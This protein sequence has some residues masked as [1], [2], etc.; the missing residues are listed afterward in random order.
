MISLDTNISSRDC[1]VPLNLVKD[2]DSASCK[3]DII[4]FPTLGGVSQWNAV[5]LFWYLPLGEAFAFALASPSHIAKLVFCFLVA[6]HGMGNLL[7]V[8][9]LL[10]FVLERLS[11]A[12]IANVVILNQ[13]ILV[14]IANQTRS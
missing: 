5:E 6:V 8:M 4:I 12:R 9:A 14:L 7:N 10:A 2:L 3:L 13:E 11:P 1:H